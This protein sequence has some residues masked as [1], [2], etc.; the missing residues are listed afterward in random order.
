MKYLIIGLGNIGLEYKN[1]RH[2]I[3]FQVLDAFCKASNIVFEQKKYA[4]VADM[5]FRGKKIILVKPTTY[6]NLSGKAV[7]YWLQKEKIPIINSLTIVDDINL[8]FGDIRIK[9]KGSHGGH[10]GLI[11]ICNTLGN[12]NFPRMRFGIGND[13]YSGQQADYVLSEWKNQEL[14][15]LPEKIETMTEAIKSFISIG[16][17][18]TMNEFN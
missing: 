2:N 10:N 13:F 4:Y 14:E 1:T 6:M 7:N 8:D 18:R 11:H 9:P 16:I 5:K 3:G 17:E 15:Y 12:C